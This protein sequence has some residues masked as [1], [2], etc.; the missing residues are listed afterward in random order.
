MI[1]GIEKKKKKN[2]SEVPCD[3][4]PFEGEGTEGGSV[5][6][7]GR[8]L[9]RNTTRGGNEQET[10]HRC[11]PTERKPPKSGKKSREPGEKKKKTC[12]SGPFSERSLPKINLF[13]RRG[14]RKIEEV[15]LI[16]SL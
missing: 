2:S 10:G 3:I 8:V 5:E 13:P 9:S 6:E 4:R 11:L 12:V 16:S 15:R 7:K 14:R 1:S